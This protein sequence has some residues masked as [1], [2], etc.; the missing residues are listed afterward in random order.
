MEVHV[1][2]AMHLRVSSDTTTHDSGVADVY[3][4]NE[5]AAPDSGDH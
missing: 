3:E 1:V 5:A 2:A 4:S